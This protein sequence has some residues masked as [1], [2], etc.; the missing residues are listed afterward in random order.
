MYC[1]YFYIICAIKVIPFL[2][3][4]HTVYARSVWNVHSKM[5]SLDKYLYNLTN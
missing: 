2:W 4:L 3:Y 5:E 1:I